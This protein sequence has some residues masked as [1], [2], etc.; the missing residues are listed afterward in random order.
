[1]C[2]KISLRHHLF[3]FSYSRQF[4]KSNSLIQ[5]CSERIS[6][7]APRLTR[8]INLSLLARW[9]HSEAETRVACV[10]SVS[11]RVSSKERG[12]GVKDRA[13]NGA[14]KRPGRVGKKGRK[15][16]Q[17]NPRILKTAHLACHAWV[18]TPTFDVVSSCH[19]WPIKCLAFRGAE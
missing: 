7:K 11:V 13:T 9:S 16:L 8:F 4:F 6:E 17:T 14:S 15:R 19:N 5:V 1:M 2:W 12:K 3:F 18:R 10:A